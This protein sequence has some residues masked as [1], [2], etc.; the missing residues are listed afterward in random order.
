LKK[1]VSVWPDFIRSKGGGFSPNLVLVVT[2][3]FLVITGNR[4]FFSELLQA[5]P[6]GAGNMT[7]VASVAMVLVCLLVLLMLPFSNRFMLKPMLA[8]LLP[9]TALTGYFSDTYGTVIDVTMITNA[10]ETDRAEALDLINTGLLL[11]LAV[12]GIMPAVLLWNTP[13]R[14]AGWRRELASRAKLLG[15]AIAAMLAATLPLSAHYSTFIREYKPV[16]YFANPLFPLASAI[17][18]LSG[19]DTGSRVGPAAV[20]G[21]EAHVPSFSPH[22][23][24]MILVVGETARADHFSLYGYRRDTN[25]ELAKIKDLVVYRDVRSCGTS[26][27]VSVPCMFSQSNRAD[28]KQDNAR[29]TENALDVLKHAGVSIYWLDNNSSSKGVADRVSYTDYK[30]PENNPVCDIECRDVGMLPGLQKLIDG[31][32]GDILIVLHQ[33]GSH[34]PAYS[35]RYPAEFE[36]FKPTCRNSRL[37]DC[38]TDEIVNAYDNTILYTDWFLSKVIDVLKHN[39]SAF[40]TMMLYVSDHGESLGENGI[41]LHGAPY[42]FAP[43]AQTRIPLLVWQGAF[44]DVDEASLAAEAARPQSHDALFQTLLNFYEIEDAMVKPD[45]GLF[46]VNREQ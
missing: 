17:G 11:R 5:F 6:P 32:K 19:K 35:K 13:I 42:L 43:D 44:N 27:A 2:A 15:L 8:L 18:F 23:E 20:I 28:F 39:E 22:R 31:S 10:V 38:G 36:R 16:R 14:A 41:Y 26:T 37:S 4:R 25:P 1:P 29:H 46:K 45:E 3:V 40:E 12:F 34:G 7:F 30:L 24:L 33:M 21:A 9:V